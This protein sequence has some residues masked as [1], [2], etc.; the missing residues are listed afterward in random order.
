MTT[1]APLFGRPA[2]HKWRE[3]DDTYH[4]LLDWFY[5]KRNPQKARPIARRLER[6]LSEVK[7]DDPTILS[8]GAWALVSECKG[9]LP[10]AIKHREKEIRLMKRLLEIASKA[11]DPKAIL[12][13]YDYSDLADRLD[14]LAILH[15]DAGN[16]DQAI[17]LLRQSKLLCEHHAIPFDGKNLLEDYLAEKESASRRPHKKAV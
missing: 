10:G 5:D 2:I 11:K 8:E 9:D 6:L 4:Q 15:R 17:K 14:L 12:K 13:H 3:I 1:K 7:S 16:L